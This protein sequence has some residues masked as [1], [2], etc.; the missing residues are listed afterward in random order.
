MNPALADQ[1]R[2]LFASAFGAAPEIMAFA[3]G[4]VNLIGEHTDYSGGFVFPAAIQEGI[5]VAAIRSARGSTCLIS[6]SMGPAEPFDAGKVNPG[7]VSDWGKYAA[8]MAHM[9]KKSG[10][11]IPSDIDAVVVSDLPMGSGVSSSAALEMAFGTLWSSAFKTQVSKVDLALMGQAAE[12]IFAGVQTGIMDQLA[13]VLG[14]KGCALFLDT[15]SLECRPAPLP[16]STVMVLCDTLT[17]RTLAGSKYNERREQ[18]EAA[19][20]FLGVPELRDANIEMLEK[21]QPHDELLWRRAKHVVTENQ[22]CLDFLQALQNDDLK[23]AGRLINESHASLRDDYEVS[24]PALDAMADAAQRSPGCI[25]ARMT[26]AG[27]GGA[28]IAV[29]DSGSLEAFVSECETEF[30]SSF[31]QSGKLTPCSAGEGAR[32]IGA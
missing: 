1:A 12:N 17:P 31:G 21:L 26:G 18:I 9:L 23:E 8:G 10:S 14:Q 11:G 30:S 16:E 7:D 2:E 19:A 24:S 20:R 6:S 5:C 4:R 13:S 32:L 22:R 27:F 25:G 3:P 15:R 28:C 29:V